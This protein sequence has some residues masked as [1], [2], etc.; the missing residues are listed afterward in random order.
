MVGT[1]AV[2]V[3]ASTIFEIDYGEGHLLLIIS[4]Y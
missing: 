1:E 3:I 2:Y 4:N